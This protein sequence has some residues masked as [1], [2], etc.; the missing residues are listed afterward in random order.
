MCAYSCSRVW[1]SETSWI[2]AFQAPLSLGILQARTLE[3]VAMSSSRG[4]SQPR[5][6]TQVSYC[7]WILYWLSHQGSP[8][9]LEWVAYPFSRGSSPSRILIRVSCIAG[10]FFISWATREAHFSIGTSGLRVIMNLRKKHKEKK[11]TGSHGEAVAEREITTVIIFRK[12][13]FCIFP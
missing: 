10:K 6:W 5:D 11:E 12:K 3:W 2:A 9:I 4:S 13:E 8:R 1:L 7:R